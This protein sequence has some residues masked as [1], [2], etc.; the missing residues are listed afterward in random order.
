MA[1]KR[2]ILDL[3]INRTAAELA[4]IEHELIGFE[5]KES[6]DEETG[7]IVKYTKIELEV[8]RNSGTYSRCR[9][10]VKIVPQIE[11]PFTE[12]ELGEGV[13]VMLKGLTIS[14]INGRNIYFKAD[15]FEQVVEL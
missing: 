3:M 11:C 12:E 5:N 2:D 6:K 10:L 14:Y 4:D 8:P 1:G 15:S 13:P 9:F 7:E